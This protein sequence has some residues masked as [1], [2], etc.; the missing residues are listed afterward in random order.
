M[1]GA[2]TP[3][4]ARVIFDLGA[5]LPPFDEPWSLIAETLMPKGAVALHVARVAHGYPGGLDN[6]PQGFC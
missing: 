1:D 4:I 6:Q 3:Y 5:K 2:V